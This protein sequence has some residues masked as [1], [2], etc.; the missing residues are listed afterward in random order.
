MN[1]L[2]FHNYSVDLNQMW[3]ASHKDLI[4]KIAFEL[5]CPD[6]I[7]ELTEKLLG[8][9]LKLKRYKDE[10]APK[11]PKTGFQYFCDEFRPKIKKKNNTIRLGDMMKELGALWRSYDDEQKAPYLTK[12]NECKLNYDDALEEYNNNLY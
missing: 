1:G 2:Q 3:Y 4:T 12:Y 7:N 9:E 10:N 8:P 11:K 5:N 6:R